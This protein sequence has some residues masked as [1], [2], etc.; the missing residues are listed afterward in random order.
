[1]ATPWKLLT[2]YVK[3]LKPENLFLK[4]L[5]GKNKKYSPISQLVIRTSGTPMSVAKVRK[6]GSDALAV[7]VLGTFQEFTVTVPEIFEYDFI[8]ETY[9]AGSLLPEDVDNVVTPEKIARQLNEIY[10]EKAT[11]LKKRVDRAIEKKFAELLEGSVKLDD[12]SGT[13]ILSYNIPTPEAGTF[14]WSDASAAAPLDDLELMAEEFSDNYGIRPKLVLMSGDVA[15]RFIRTAQVE[16]F[17]NKNTFG[18]G[19]LKPS[20]TADNVKF[21][22]KF[23]EFGIPE[24][25]VYSGTYLDDEGVAQKYIADGKIY[26]LSPEGFRLGFGAIIDFDVD[27]SGKPFKLELLAKEKIINNGSAKAIFVRSKPLPYLINAN[28]IIKNDV[29]LS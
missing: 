12:P 9:A 19:S 7:N 23:E 14:D 27:K 13:T 18:W 11:E 15:R 24:I 22:G 17:I 21:I 8:D 25:Y 1:M 2:E 10:G 5:L 29:T 26:M 4:K 3:Q 16:K 28:T 6:A 20:Y